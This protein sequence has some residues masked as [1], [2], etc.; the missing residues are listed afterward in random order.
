MNTLKALLLLAVAS[1]SIFTF[2]CT[3]SNTNS[4]STETSVTWGAEL[5]T[6]SITASI[7]GKEQ[8]TLQAITMLQIQRVRLLVKELKAKPSKD[9]TGA[10]DKQ[11]KLSPFVIEWLPNQT[12]V[13]AT[14]LLPI[15]EYDQAKFQ[16]HRFTPPEVTQYQ[17]D[18]IFRDFVLPDRATAII[19]GTVSENG[20]SQAFIYRSDATANLNLNFDNV[21]TVASSGTTTIV[22]QFNPLLVFKKGNV[23]LDPRDTKN[24][25]DIDNLIRTA[26]R[27]F[28]R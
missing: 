15:G 4:G 16:I 20:V 11:V 28:K 25:N 17:N 1:T 10:S 19:E 6:T 26:I 18:A 24:R 2:A 7:S 5:G 21:I 8:S 27:T 22:M 23:L 12:T 14:A 9:N 13:F 3:N